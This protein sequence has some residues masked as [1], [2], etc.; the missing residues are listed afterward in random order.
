MTHLVF[1]DIFGEGMFTRK[2]V[3]G[4][5]RLF[6]SY[7]LSDGLTLVKP[8]ETEWIDAELLEVTCGLDVWIYPQ[9]WQMKVY[10]NP[11]PG[12]KHT[13]YRKLNHGQFVVVVLPFDAFPVPA[14]VAEMTQ[15]VYIYIIYIVSTG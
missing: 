14:L 13:G 1:E 2:M 6:T 15:Y 9:W 5:I 12:D 11:P 4:K 8:L 3:F 7:F 10:R